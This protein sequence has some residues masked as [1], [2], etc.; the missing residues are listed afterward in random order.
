V[1]H[2]R[3]C[4]LKRL[5][6]VQLTTRL[7]GL[8]ADREDRV[9]CGKLVVTKSRNRGSAKAEGDPVLL[10]LHFHYFLD[11]LAIGTIDDSA[12]DGFLE[13]EIE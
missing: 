9:L 1:V 7:L 8:R 4:E 5:H 11:Y 10:R 6:L 12:I 2:G 13:D 3:I